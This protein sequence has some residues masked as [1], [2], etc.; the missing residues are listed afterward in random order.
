MEEVFP[1]YQL[2]SENSRQ[3]GCAWTSSRRHRQRPHYS[4]TISFEKTKGSRSPTTA[5]DPPPT[6]YQSISAKPAPPTTVLEST[7]LE[8][9]LCVAFPE[10]TKQT[11]LRWINQWRS[12]TEYSRAQRI[13]L[14]CTA[15]SSFS[16]T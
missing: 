1:P 7:R 5:T 6:S 13:R 16:R 2:R 12:W 14:N 3:D 15:V 8:T 9:S 11:T 10:K 4:L